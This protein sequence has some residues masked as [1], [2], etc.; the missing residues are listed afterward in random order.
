MD[1]GNRQSQVMAEL[2]SVQN[3]MDELE[4]AISTLQDRL[5]TVRY[6]GP[7]ITGP[8]SDTQ[9]QPEAL[10]PLA[11]VIRRMKDRFSLLIGQLHQLH[12][13]IEV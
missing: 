6:V 4:K 3:M 7:Q 2:T 11:D 10:C 13:E 9:K 8:P 1:G 5:A 12:R